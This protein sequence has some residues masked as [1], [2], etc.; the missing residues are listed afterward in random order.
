MSQSLITIRMDEN[1]KREFDFVCNELGMN[2]ST[3]VTIFAKQVC[4]DGGIPFEITLGQTYKEGKF[5]DRKI[6]YKVYVYCHRIPEMRETG[7]FNNISEAM[8]Y[9]VKTEESMYDKLRENIETDLERVCFTID[10]LYLDENG[11]AI[12]LDDEGLRYRRNDIETD[13]YYSNDMV[14]SFDG[15]LYGVVE[16]Y[17]RN[18]IK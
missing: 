11:H 9:L 17:M 16:G 13:I 4:R 6:E 14:E 15:Y 8:E 5:L 2:I 12:I 7:C 3:A 10:I 1:L 18:L